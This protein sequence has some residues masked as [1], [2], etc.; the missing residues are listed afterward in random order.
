MARVTIA[1]EPDLLLRC[2]GTEL[3][4]SS[5]KLAAASP[6]FSAMFTPNF[7][8]GLALR[9]AE[10]SL[11][12]VMLPEDSALGMEALCNAIHHPHTANLPTDGPSVLVFA[13]TVEK[14]LCTQSIA[15][16]T[17]KLLEK[18][19]PDWD[20]MK[21]TCRDDTSSLPTRRRYAFPETHTSFRS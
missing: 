1:E 12:V 20:N 16:T 18:L 10:E 19:D 2:E 7:K 11:P 5:P 6:V 9:T 4:V 21:E 3:L 14:Y 8:E 15:D 17:S 13:A